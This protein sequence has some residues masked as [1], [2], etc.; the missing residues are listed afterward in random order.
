MSRSALS[1]TN[2]VMAGYSVNQEG[3]T[4][5]LRQELQ[6]K[7][8]SSMLFS[9]C[10]FSVERSQVFCVFVL[11]SSLRHDPGFSLSF[12]NVVYKSFVISGKSSGTFTLLF[13]FLS[14]QWSPVTKSCLPLPPQG[15]FSLSSVLSCNS[16]GFASRVSNSVEL[17][18]PMFNHGGATYFFAASRH[19]RQTLSKEIRHQMDRQ[20]TQL[21]QQFRAVTRQGP[22]HPQCHPRRSHDKSRTVKQ[23]H[24][25]LS[26]CQSRA[27][28]RQPRAIV[29][30]L[31]SRLR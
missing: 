21:R 23:Q 14:S 27:T 12:Q 20:W 19:R 4:Y 26:I 18:Q 1:D 16:Q 25:L 30:R 31:R 13:P 10:S 17:A 24:R 5:L 28:S 2:L 8:G 7:E 22:W 15:S 11:F 29:Q 3:A 6:R 9:S